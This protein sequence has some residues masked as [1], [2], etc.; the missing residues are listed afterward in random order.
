MFIN[1]ALREGGIRAAQAE[2]NCRAVPDGAGQLSAR[3]LHA[4]SAAVRA[5]AKANHTVSALCPRKLRERSYVNKRGIEDSFEDPFAE[6]ASHRKG[7]SKGKDEDE[8][9]TPDA[10]SPSS[11]TATPAAAERA[12]T[13]VPVG[14]GAR[15]D[16]KAAQPVVAIDMSPTGGRGVV[17][18]TARRRHVA[19]DPE[20]AEGAAPGPSRRRGVRKPAANT[21][22]PPVHA[23]SRSKRVG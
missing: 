20:D 19:F 10:R 3:R 2:E 12:S 8:D 9:D 18:S 5:W 14:K 21:C 7:K 1:R 6:L 22:V 17:L 23:M 16:D 11:A 13:I 15:M 4:P